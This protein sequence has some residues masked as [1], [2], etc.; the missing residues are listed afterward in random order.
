MFYQ[1]K[2][3]MLYLLL[4]ANFALI[5]S[6]RAQK[7]IKIAFI[8][9]IH[10]HDI[11]PEQD[12]AA[13]HYLYD[14]TAHKTILIRSL[15]SEM[16]STRLFNENYYALHQALLEIAQK[17]I[18]L[19]IIPGDLTD[20]GQLVNLTAVKEILS[21]YQQQYHMRFL[22]TNGN[23]DVSEPFE[24][25]SGK[26]DFLSLG[27]EPIG[28]YS[29]TALVKKPHDQVYPLL[30]VG[31]YQAVF[32]SLQSFGFSPSSEDLFYTTPHHTF[33]YD[34]YR[35]NATMF[36]LNKRWY[37]YG[38]DSFPDLTYLAEPIKDLWVMA[39]DGNIFEKRN[40][41]SFDNIDDGYKFIHQK[42]FL[43]S[44]IKA[45]VAEAKKRGKTL[46]AFSHYPILD[47]NNGH[48]P[49]LKKIIGA[50]KFQLSRVPEDS[51]QQFF[52]ESGLQVHFGGHMHINQHGYLRRDSGAV[53]WNIQVPSLAAFPPAYKIASVKYDA[54]RITTYPL[55]NVIHYNELFNYYDR[56]KKDSALSKIVKASGNYYQFTRNHL[57]YLA[58]NRFYYNEFDNAAWDAFKNNPSAEWIPDS[59]L[60]VFTKKEQNIFLHITFIDIIRDL[61]FIRNGNDLGIKEIPAARLKLYRRWAQLTATSK[62]PSL[63]DKLITVMQQMI[64]DSIS[65][66]TT[67]M[68][69][70]TK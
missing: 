55:K 7:E 33:N 35:Y 28:V 66:T 53:M 56:E 14:S 54:I 16:N 52:L 37:H 34:A 9:D 5:T 39:I 68:K 32:N 22:V 50:D 51:I 70:V 19:V 44:W 42:P 47:F 60:H 43:L 13:L 31:G 45:M 11:Y 1:L 10:I 21:Y 41:G 30:K 64:N 62:Y 67:S 8:S 2:A 65:T 61:Y 20:D 49:A 24:T 29:S 3:A 59:L 38:I 36:D 26:S 48:S 58:N 4:V 40:D 12:T 69:L 57:Q 46:I 17:G 27:G 63:L 15:N 25:E 6:A 18:K 23:H